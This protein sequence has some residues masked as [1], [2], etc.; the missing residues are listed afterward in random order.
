MAHPLLALAT[1]AVTAAGGVWYLPALAD[2]RAGA[3]R[4]VSRR[5]RAASCVT[6][7]STAAAV[8]VL[9]LT[10]DSWKWPATAA[11]AGTSL[12]AALLVRSLV[13]HSHEARE[14][15]THWTEL[16]PAQSPP[17]PDRTRHV[18][19]V[20]L[21]TG[22]T[23]AAVI[24]AL[25]LAE[26]PDTPTAWLTTITAPAAVLALFITLAATHTHHRRH[27]PH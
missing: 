2:L 3:D 5:V 27:H 10:T 23:A 17:A 15:A 6:A 9:L 22:L 13:H 25:R 19:A 7:W 26:G 20:L 11:A 12:A 8:A 4:P 24:G 18:V 16:A 14:A 21:A 1:T